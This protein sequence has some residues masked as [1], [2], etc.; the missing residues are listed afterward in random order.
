MLD[1]DVYKERINVKNTYTMQIEQRVDKPVGWPGDV[2][3][4]SSQ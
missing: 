3:S 2:Y 1:V 4:L